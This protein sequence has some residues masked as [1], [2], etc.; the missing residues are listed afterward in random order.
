MFDELVLKPRAGHGGV[1]VLIAPRATRAEIEA[2]RAAVIADPGAWI[3]QRMVMLSTHPT[4]VEGGQV[5]AAPHRPA[6]VRVPRRG[7][8]AARAA[9]RAHARGARRGCAGGELVPERRGEGHLGA[10]L[11]GPSSRRAVEA[12][13]EARRASLNRRT[14]PSSF[15]TLVAR[16]G[17]V[18][19]AT[20]SPI[21]SL[22]ALTTK[23]II[24]T[25]P[26]MTARTTVM[27][28]LLFTT[29]PITPLAP[30]GRRSRAGSGR[31]ARASPRP[32]ERGAGL[33]GRLGEFAERAVAVLDRGEQARER[34][35]RASGGGGARAPRTRGRWRRRAARARRRRRGSAA[36][37]AWISAW[38]PADSRLV[39]WPGT[40]PT[41]RPSSAAKSAVVSEPERSV[42]WTTTVAAPSAAM[43][44][45]RAMKHHR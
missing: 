5:R 7:L 16:V 1:G 36:R 10:A 28:T 13:V 24:A 8:Q 41:A 31:G 15:V 11:G 21:R 39:T 23:P 43:M 42:A 27:K 9:G 34:L 4:V 38:V 25:L 22:S 19:T 18:H 20:T 33:V 45:L 17:A 12:L 6:A 29:S 26:A 30:S 44:R 40:A 14:S 32:D 3:A 37:P 2:T 35:R